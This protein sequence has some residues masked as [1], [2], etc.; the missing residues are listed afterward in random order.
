MTPVLDEPLKFELWHRRRNR[1]TITVVPTSA[2]VK[3]QWIN[4]INSLLLSQAAQIRD[5]RMRELAELGL[6]AKPYL[7]IEGSDA[8]TDR[9]IQISNIRPR[10]RNS[11]AVSSFDNFSSI[12]SPRN[13]LKRRP[14]SLVSTASS[15][16]SVSSPQLI[17]S[18]NLHLFSPEL[19]SS[20]LSPRS[21][22]HSRSAPLR[23]LSG[24]AGIAPPQLTSLQE[25]ESDL[26]SDAPQTVRIKSYRQYETT[27]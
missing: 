3:E 24:R 11:V 5:E 20:S 27:V 12:S 2:S 1:E 25:D 22:S 14:N 17:N 9:S 18:L 15:S 4:E 21:C 7:N 19:P 16:E 26:E 10:M 23:H 6:G 8:I 13:L